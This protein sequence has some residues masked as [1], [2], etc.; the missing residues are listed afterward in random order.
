MG[1]SECCPCVAFT[2]HAQTTHSSLLASA[3][4]LC[5]TATTAAAADAATAMQSFTAKGIHSL[6]LDCGRAERR[7][8]TDGLDGRREEGADAHEAG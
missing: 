3:A 5:L 7:D 4:A 6:N 8:A 2:L 1:L